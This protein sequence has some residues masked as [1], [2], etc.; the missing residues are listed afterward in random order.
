MS[1]LQHALVALAAEADLRARFR[2]EG[3]KAFEARF[4]LD[5]RSQK[6]LLGIPFEKL[7]RYGRSLIGK[8]WDDVAKVVPL[9]RTIV[10]TLEGR[11]RTW[12]ASHP[13]PA[14]DTVLAP[15]VAEAARA[16]PVLHGALAADR[17][18]AVFAAD[19]LAFEVLLAC[20]R[21]DGVPR[22]LRSRFRISEIA[23]DMRRGLIPIDPDLSPQKLIFRRSGVE[24]VT[25]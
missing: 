3:V 14:L 13:A 9:T 21:G 15:G 7:E 23:F 22:S 17:I 12:L 24:A 25:L 20:A 8:R 4:S 10:P 11:Y 18:L 16:L 1:E 19:L 6:A 5:A 2:T